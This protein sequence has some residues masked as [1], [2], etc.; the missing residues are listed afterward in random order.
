MDN[1]K[2]FKFTHLCFSNETEYKETELPTWLRDKE[3]LWFLNKYVLA[4]EVGESV[5]TD[6]NRITRV[7]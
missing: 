3:R 5:D 6:F 2:V 7:V 1:E 4:L